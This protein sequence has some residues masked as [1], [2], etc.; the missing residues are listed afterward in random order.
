MKAGKAFEIL[1]K[2]ILLSVGFSEVKSDGIYIFDAAPGQ[3]I[4]GLGAAHN[5][6]VLLNPPVQ[7][8]FY[9]PSRLLIECKDYTRKV[10]MPTIRNALGLREDIN[11]F[12][13]VDY[14]ELKGR[15]NTRKPALTYSYTRYHYQV[16]VASMSG[17]TLPAQ[18]F[19]ATHRIPLIEFYDMPFWDNFIEI[20]LEL[21]RYEYRNDDYLIH[22]IEE[23][24]L[25]IGRRT[26]IA[27]TNTVQLLF[28]YNLRNNTCHFDNSYNLY[29]ETSSSLWQLHS[30]N[31]LYTFQLP[32][33]IAKTWIENANNEFDLLTSAIN[34]KAE[35]LSNM[36]VYY[37]DYGIPKVKMI[38]IDKDQLIRAKAALQQNN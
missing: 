18:Q 4:N 33:D 31:N 15:Q 32:K 27:I 30:G 36:I 38:S 8:P 29:W 10:G 22:H 6:D 19:A 34:C 20:I 3:M 13:V 14:E 7:T 11:S 9:T 37:S 24:G 2:S 5:A 12:E 21:N 26:A 35:Y 17:Y 16:A 25:S 1:V 28:L 23:L